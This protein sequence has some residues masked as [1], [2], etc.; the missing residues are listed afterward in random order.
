MG[1]PSCLARMSN[2]GFLL[3]EDRRTQLVGLVRAPRLVHKRLSGARALPS[4]TIW[5][6]SCNKLF[7]SS[8]LLGRELSCILP[9]ALHHFYGVLPFAL[10]PALC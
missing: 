4:S 9:I 7:S 3:E 1:A 2:G 6:F 5:V 10:V 8:G